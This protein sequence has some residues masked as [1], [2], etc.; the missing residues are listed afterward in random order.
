VGLANHAWPHHAK[1][2]SSTLKIRLEKSRDTSHLPT[3]P[4]EET[5]FLL[6]NAAE[7]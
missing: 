4:Y 5:M 3:I 6:V 1:S 7:R 2:L